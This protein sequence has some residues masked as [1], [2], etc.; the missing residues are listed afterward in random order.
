MASALGINGITE[1][2]SLTPGQGGNDLWRLRRADADLVLR[3][4]PVGAPA[5]VA[6]RE[7]AVH[8]HVRRNGLSAP[9]VVAVGMAENRPVLAMTWSPGQRLADALWARSVPVK[10][11][12]RACGTTLAALHAIAAAP[13]T[14][15]GDRDWIA[16]AGERSNVLEPLLRPY[17]VDRTL[18]HL[19]F[20]P[21]NL[22]IDDARTIT[23]LDWANTRIGP[24]QADLARTLSILEL[25]EV[26]HP[27]MTPATRTLV[28]VFRDAFLSG[29]AAAGGDPRVDDAVLAW[30]YAVQ[31]HDL[32]DSWVPHWY[33]RRLDE[34]YREL[35][36]GVAP[37]AAGG[38]NRP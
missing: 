25:V 28:D 10:E 6:E 1:I 24:S 2:S 5:V 35:A 27:T 4:F 20:H 11:L 36:G 9:A 33:F 14:L 30:A 3:A 16:W 34:R 8:E 19:D 23:V 32:T 15:V 26:A 21:E 17:D 7:A 37:P 13:P 12:G 29:Y 22:I 18:L 31:C 38:Q